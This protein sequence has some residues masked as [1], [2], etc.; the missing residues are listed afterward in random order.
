[1]PEQSFEH[2]SYDSHSR[3]FTSLADPLSR[4]KEKNTIN[5]WRHERMYNLCM[6]LIKPGQTWLSVGDGLGT[7]AHW[8]LSK[9]VEAT[10]SDLNTEVLAE[11]SRQGFIRSFKQVNAEQIPYANDSVDYLMCKEAY[12]HFPRPSIALY[13]MTRVADKAV[14]LIEPTDIGIQMPLMVALKNIL[15][16]FD[17]SLINTIW[18]N[19]YSFEAVGNY[20]F[21]IS[22]RE[23]EKIAMG[24]NLPC[25]AFKGFNDYYSDKLDFA[26]PVSNKTLLNRVKR[27]IGFRDLLC[28]LSLIPYQQTCAVLFKQAPD[29]QTRA[30]M[31]KMG[32]KI[33]DLKANPYLRKA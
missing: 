8:L 2:L 33:I 9:G 13:E 22:E 18:K 3:H 20:V 1:M 7:D 32:Y 16:R 21:K 29:A 17:T 11:A 12:H 6:P 19:R 24:I 28:K 25:I 31:L 23:I 4:L 10:A 30:G 15:D 14:V 27:K 26:A 5:L